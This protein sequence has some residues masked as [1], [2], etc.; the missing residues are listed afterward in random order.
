MW[1]L[2]V[3]DSK[4]CL[5]DSPHPTP[6]CAPTGL[7]GKERRREVEGVEELEDRHEQGGDSGVVGALPWG[8]RQEPGPQPHPGRRGGGSSQPG[9][10]CAPPGRCQG[11]HNGAPGMGTRP[12]HSAPNN[13]CSTAAGL[14]ASRGR[15]TGGQQMGLGCQISSLGLGEQA[16][17]EGEGEGSGSSPPPMAPPSLWSLKEGGRDRVGGGGD[18]LPTITAT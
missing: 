18:S 8:K 17:L 3:T 2:P 5:T 15:R 10:A 14:A 7:R 6:G 12:G 9:R 1:L 4:K 13:H 16:A 11:L